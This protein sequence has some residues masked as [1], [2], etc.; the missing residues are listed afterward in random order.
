MVQDAKNL[1]YSRE[2]FQEMKSKYDAAS[3]D[4]CLGMSFDEAA[5]HISQD[6]LVMTAAEA[7]KYDENHDGSIN[8]EEYLTMRLEYDSRR[9]D[10]RG[11]FL[12]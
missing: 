12:A 5:K 3:P 8:F 2:W 4:R 9:Q 1:Y 6:G 11:R 7:E 10:K